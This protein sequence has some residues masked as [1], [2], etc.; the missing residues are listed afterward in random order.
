MTSLQY[1]RLREIASYLDDVRGRLANVVNAAPVEL[2]NRAR[3]DD[4][5]NGTQIIQHLGKVEGSTTKL[6]EGVFAKE[7]ERGLDEDTETT[8]LLGSMDRF[9]SDGAILRP[10]VAPQRLRPEA[11]PD[12]VASWQS[13]QAVRERTYRAFATVDGKDLTRVTAPH[14]FFGPLNAYE[15]LLFIGKH[16]ERHLGQLT[17]ELASP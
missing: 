1:P 17:R 10:L 4:R 13:L 16:E 3:P 12:F 15:W 9:A 14:P 6:L 5:W 2:M 11:T 7:L 8:S